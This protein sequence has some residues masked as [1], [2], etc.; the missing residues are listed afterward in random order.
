MSH[1]SNSFLIVSLHWNHFPV[2][3]FL[4]LSQSHSLVPVQ[5][6]AELIHFLEHPRETQ[7]QF[8][9]G[10]MRRNHLEKILR[11]HSCSVTC[12]TERKRT[13]HTLIVT[14]TRAAAYEKKMKMYQNEKAALS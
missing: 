12:A 8:K 3:Q 1:F 9:M 13:P 6:C 5:D 11:S 7:H 10:I 4:G 14:K 2:L